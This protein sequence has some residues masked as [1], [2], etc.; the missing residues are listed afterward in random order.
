[1]NTTTKAQ[2]DQLVTTLN[3]MTGA[4]SAGEPF[5]ICYAYSGAR[6]VQEGRTG[7]QRDI[8]PRGT[9]AQT[10][11]YINAMIAGIDARLNYNTGA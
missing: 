2:L 5:G 7:C 6:L 8:S 9:K 4:A 11:L 1:M 3:N 10:A